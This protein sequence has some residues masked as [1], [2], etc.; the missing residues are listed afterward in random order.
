MYKKL[1]IFPL[2]WSNYGYWKS[3]NALDF[4]TSIF[5]YFFWQRIASKKMLLCNHKLSFI[6]KISKSEPKHSTPCLKF[7]CMDEWWAI[8]LQNKSLKTTLHASR[9][10]IARGDTNKDSEIQTVM[11]A[12]MGV[13][14]PIWWR[15]YRPWRM[16]G[17]EAGRIEF[18]VP[19]HDI[20][21][22]PTH[23]RSTS[24]LIMDSYLSNQVLTQ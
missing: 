19:N 24:Q 12:S 17:R 14:R 9:C 3:Q 7:L 22:S 10:V 20:S 16:A 4:T 21:R 6:F 1:A 23:D 18:E 13:Y 5:D 15:S 11:I 2:I 8:W